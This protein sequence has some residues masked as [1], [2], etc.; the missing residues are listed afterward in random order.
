MKTVTLSIASRNDV[1]CRA[2]AAFNGKQQGAW[3]S[4]ASADMLWETFTKRR[5]SLLRAMIGQGAMTVQ[6]ASRRVKRNI[7]IVQGDVKVL[8]DA[9]MLEGTDDGRILFPYDAVHVDFTLR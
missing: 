6:E 9:G 8:L 2:N 7:N 3:I 5:W 1:T 4:F